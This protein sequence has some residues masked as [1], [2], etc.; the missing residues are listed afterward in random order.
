MAM[1][2]KSDEDVALESP[3]PELNRDIDL[4]VVN[5]SHLPFRA[6]TYRKIAGVSRSLTPKSQ[7]R[8]LF[9]LPSAIR[10]RIYGFCFPEESRHITLS[11]RFATKAVFG[12]AYFADPWDILEDV[13]G[14]LESFGF[15]RKDLLTYFWSEYHFHVTVNAFSGPKLSP[16]SHVWLLQHVGSIKALTVEID[17][18]RFGGSCRK[19]APTFGYNMDKENKQLLAIFN[20]LAKRRDASTIDELNILCRQ[21]AGFRPQTD[22]RSSESSGSEPGM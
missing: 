14:G 5:E 16:L 6:A 12:P 8:R 18:T 3:V 4:M 1:R 10:R 15:L 22:R 11:P 7:A 13:R 19:L 17:Y 21:Y 2:F 20:G 9:T